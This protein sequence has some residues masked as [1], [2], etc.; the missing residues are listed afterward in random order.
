[1]ADENKNLPNFFLSIRLKYVKLG[2][3]YLI[4]NALYFLL[5]PAILV[6]LAH[7]SEL[8]VDD[9]IDLRENLRFDF[10]TVILC[11]VSIVFTCTLYLMS[12]PRKVYMVN[13]ACYKPEPAR[14]CTKELYMQLVKGTGTFTEESLT[15]KRKILEK[16]GIGQMTYGPEGLL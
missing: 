5:L 6:V 2:Y 3:H 12:R 10:I 1:M 4:S 15:F 14:M 16:S 13:F 8:T 7:L 9:F 11:S